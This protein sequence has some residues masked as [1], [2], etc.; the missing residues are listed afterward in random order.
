[1]CSGDVEAGIELAL[2][3][4]PRA[5]AC[6]EL[7]P[8]AP[9]DDVELERADEER[10]ARV[11]AAPISEAA[12]AYAILAHRWLVGSVDTFAN[13]T[14]PIVHNALDVIAWDHILIA[15]KLH[16]ALHG[17]DEYQSCDP[18]ADDDDPVQNDWNGSAKV[19]LISIERS[20]AA[21]RVIGSCTPGETPAMMTDHLAQLLAEIE[22]EFP[23]ARRF[24]RPGFDES[25][26]A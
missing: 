18:L 7:S 5:D 19:A 16:R 26:P 10:Y 12:R 13:V 22:R 21:W 24:V 17:R 14:D 15:A 8:P 23:D 25:P 20:E 3:G 4:S 9:E 6:A 11:D 1:M 2:G